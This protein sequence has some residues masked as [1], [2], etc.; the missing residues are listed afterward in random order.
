MGNLGFSTP[1]DENIMRALTPR[2]VKVPPIDHYDGTTDPIDHLAA[3]KAQMS[4]LTSSE[5]A[6]CKFFPTTLKGLALTWFTELPFGS[7]SS[8]TALETA[9]KQNFIAG[10]RH[11]K[12]SIHLMSIRQRRE[13]DLADYIKR[14][15]EESL[16]VSD[17]QNSVAFTALMSGLYPSSRFTLKLAESEASSFSEAMN[18]AQ[19]FIQA[20]DI[21]KMHEEPSSGK[22]KHEYTPR[23]DNPRDVPRKEKDKKPRLE[24]HW[25]DPQYNL[26]QR[27]I[28]LDIKGK[29]PLPKPNPIRTSASKRDKRL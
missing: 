12:T 20:S 5:A 17:L 26:N 14:F 6:W 2:K 10:R 7:I 22:K 28:Y 23:A 15:N 1:F 3:F 21:S 8:F 11:R 9:F 16:K 13:E 19:K 18:L 24:N 25:N 27:E 29:Y 4:V